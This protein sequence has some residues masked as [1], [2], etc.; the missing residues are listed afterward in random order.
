MTHA[1]DMATRQ[2]S[3]QVSR[4]N[5][6][7][8]VAKAADFDLGQRHVLHQTLQQRP[9]PGANRPN[10]PIIH[11]GSSDCAAMMGATGSSGAMFNRR[12]APSITAEKTG[13]ATAPP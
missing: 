10:L 11:A 5:Q 8:I 7:A 13:A 1:M 12:R 6:A 4:A 2:G 3:E 9:E